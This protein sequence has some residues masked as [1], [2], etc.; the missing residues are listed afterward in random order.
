MVFSELQP[1]KAESPI[2]VTLLWMVTFDER[3]ARKKG[4]GISVICDG[5]V[6]VSRDVQAVKDFPRK[7]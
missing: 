3:C 4:F 5:I 7:S 2:E 6:N 1:L